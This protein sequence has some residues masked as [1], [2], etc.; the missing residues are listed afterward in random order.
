MEFE[1]AYFVK[2]KFTKNQ[3]EKNLNNALKDLDIAKKD[4]ILE[5][6][7]NYTYTALIKAGPTLLNFYHV[8]IKS[9]LG[10]HIKI[11]EKMAEILKDN[12][13]SDIG[14][15]MHSKRNLDFYNG[16]I[17][18]TEKE[19]SEYI[20]FVEKILIKVKDILMK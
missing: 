1:D 20:K 2:F 17:E 15:I 4:K 16:G 6:K 14:N 9:V 10:H 11:I 19:C 7:F 12:A 5:V 18:V 3:I 8:K 13:I